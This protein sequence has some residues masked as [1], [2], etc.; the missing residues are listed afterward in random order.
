MPHR[1]AGA[2]MDSRVGRRVGVHLTVLRDPDPCFRASRTNSTSDTGQNHMSE[3]IR[4]AGQP[5]W[6]LSPYQIQVSYGA[7]GGIARGTGAD[8]F[9]PLNPLSPIAPPDVAGRRFDFRRVTTSS[10]SRAAT[11]R[12]ALPNCAV[13]PTPTISF[14][15]SSRRARTRWSGSAGAS[16]RA[17]RPYLS[18]ACRGG[19]GGAQERGNRRRHERAHRYA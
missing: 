17:P 11:S 18:P 12:S 1:T 9:G 14:A 16:G 4:G 5:S 7:S 15:W 19:S 10:L 13:L 8:W 3:Q 2:G 6:P